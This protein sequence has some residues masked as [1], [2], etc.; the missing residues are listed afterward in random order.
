METT[1]K[2]YSY[3]NSYQLD[4]LSASELDYINRHGLPNLVH[5]YQLYLYRHDILR[6][7]VSLN[8][9]RTCIVEFIEQDHFKV[10]CLLS[11]ILEDFDPE[12]RDFYF[13]KHLDEVHSWGDCSL[14]QRSRNT[15]VISK[16]ID[17]LVFTDED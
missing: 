7:W 10:W 9:K 6:Y 16:L 1:V 8:V 3:L 15:S 14:E 4:A 12:V 11:M 5:D 17:L 2:S 13:R